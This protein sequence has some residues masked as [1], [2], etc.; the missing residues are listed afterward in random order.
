MPNHMLIGPPGA[1]KSTLAGI[2][3]DLD[4][5]RVVVSTDGIRAELF[6]DAA[7]QGPWEAVEAAVFRRLTWVSRLG[8]EAIYDATNGRREWRRGFLA[9]ARGIGLEPWIGWYLAVPLALC[10]GRNAGRDRRVPS[11]VVTGLWHELQRDPPEVWEGFAA[12]FR[13]GANPPDLLR[14]EVSTCLSAYR[15]TGA[16]D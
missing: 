3:V 9:R 11:A 1:G 10:L 2:L 7:V 12:V 13:L 16:T 5:D 8:R 4:P 15:G 14:Q 6:G